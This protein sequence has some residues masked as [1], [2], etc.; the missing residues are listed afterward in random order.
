MR[1]YLVRHGETESNRRGLAL[2]QDDVPLNEHGLWQ[3]ERVGRAL[4]S[5]PLSAVY[6]SPLRRAPA[7]AEAVAVHH[8]REV[9]VE[10]RLHEMDHGD[11]DGLTGAEIQERFPEFLERWRHD[12]PADLRMPGGETFREAQVR[13]LAAAEDI[14]SRHTESEVVVVSHN[15]SLHTLLCEALGVPLSAFRS[16]RIDLASLSV[17]ELREGGTWSVVTLNE[18][19]HLAAAGDSPLVDD[20]NG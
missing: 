6:S 3:A 16:F 19:C 17:A 10:E 7:T 2:G 12:D 14:A 18:R 15:L 5:E 4:A 20:S 11:V 9:Q 8:G 1:L 13:M